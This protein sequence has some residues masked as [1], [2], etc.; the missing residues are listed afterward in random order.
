M[1]NGPSGQ[2]WSRWLYLWPT[3]EKVISAEVFSFCFQLHISFVQIWPVQE[4]SFPTTGRK[5][6]LQSPWF[7]YPHTILNIIISLV[8]G[9][10]RFRR[11]FF[12][13]SF[14]FPPACNCGGRMCDSQTGECLADSPEVSTDTDC[15]TIS[16]SLIIKKPIINIAL[17]FRSLQIL[18]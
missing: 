16:K 7:E 14:L 8:L 2:F 4:T 5:I 15:P 1:Y 6:S 12:H 18:T 11:F 13:R 10:E 17:I 9:G 3:F